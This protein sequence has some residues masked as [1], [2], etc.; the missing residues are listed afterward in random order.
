MAINRDGNRADR[1]DSTVFFFLVFPSM[2]TT[3]REKG[4]K[5]GGRD[6]RARGK[7]TGIKAACSWAK[8]QYMLFTKREIRNAEYTQLKIGQLCRIPCAFHKGRAT[9]P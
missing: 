7:R 6:F 9:P 8:H 3:K 5:I 4:R 1:I 2:G